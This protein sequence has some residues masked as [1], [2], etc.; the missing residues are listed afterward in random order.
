MQLYYNL[1]PEVICANW[2]LSS[3]N[4]SCESSNLIYFLCHKDGNFTQCRECIWGRRE[5]WQTSK[6]SSD[7]QEPSGK[8]GQKVGQQKD[9][10]SRLVQTNKNGFHGQTMCK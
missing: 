8:S 5:F 6:A 3:S 10:L 1:M 2:L 7:S 9:Q 4:S